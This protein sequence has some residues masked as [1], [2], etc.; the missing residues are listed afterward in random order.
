MCL[1]YKRRVKLEGVLHV[2]ETD[3]RWVCSFRDGGFGVEL[4]SR[5]V[6]LRRQVLG[7][8]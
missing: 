8:V 7:W 1:A 2:L 6:C 3:N 5:S 4:G